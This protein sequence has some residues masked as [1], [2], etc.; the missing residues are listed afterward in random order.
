MKIRGTMKKNILNLF[1]IIT[2]CLIIAVLGICIFK[3]TKNNTKPDDYYNNL[4]VYYKDYLYMFD[5]STKEKTIGASS[6]VF[7]AKINSFKTTYQNNEPV[8]TYDATVIEN[9]KGN[10]VENIKITQ[11]G[12]INKDKKSA[13]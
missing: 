2:T 7:I 10:L 11:Q 1:L 6:Y 5:T 8:T 4:P 3:T 13:K 12:G 9:I